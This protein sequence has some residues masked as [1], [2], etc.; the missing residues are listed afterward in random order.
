MMYFIDSQITLNVPLSHLGGT[1]KFDAVLFHIRNL[2]DDIKY[3]SYVWNDLLQ[4]RHFN[5]RY[6]SVIDIF[7]C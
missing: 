5:Q 4:K 7:F 1:S 2:S 3:S 6:I